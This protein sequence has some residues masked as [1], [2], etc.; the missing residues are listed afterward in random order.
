[1][2]KNYFN[3]HIT[4]NPTIKMCFVDKLITDFT[5]KPRIIFSLG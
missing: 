1:M 2:C 5:T 4:K 3:S